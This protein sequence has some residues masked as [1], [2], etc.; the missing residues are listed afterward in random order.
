MKGEHEPFKQLGATAEELGASHK[1]YT[2]YNKQITGLAQELQYPDEQIKSAIEQHG[3]IQT[4]QFL[5]QEKVK[6]DGSKSQGDKDLETRLQSSIDRRL[7]PLQDAEQQRQLEVSSQ[8]FDAGFDDHYGKRY[9]GEKAMSD[10][11]KEILYDNVSAALLDDPDALGRFQAGKGADLERLF[12]A[13]A[14]RFDK[15]IQAEV[16][17][18][19][20]RVGAGG[21]PPGPGE[22]PAPRPKVSLEDIITGSPAAEKAIPSMRQRR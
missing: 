16:Q 11:A 17:R 12:I 3:L 20:Q 1:F 19:L 7:K 22:P 18:E 10:E 15:T 6:A 14:D 21:I 2:E 4:L 8:R 13:Q 9:K 5:Q